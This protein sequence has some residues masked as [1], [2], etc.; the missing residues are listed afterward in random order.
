MS[1]AI[2]ANAYNLTVQDQRC[3]IDEV[4][5]E[6]DL[7]EN[8]GFLVRGETPDGVD[9]TLWTSPYIVKR[10]PESYYSGEMDILQTMLVAGKFSAEQK[11]VMN[12]TDFVAYGWA[13]FDHEERGFITADRNDERVLWKV[14]NREYEDAPPHWAIRGEHGGIDLDLSFDA[15]VPAFDVYPHDRFSEDGIAW[16]EAYLR[17]AGTIG[18]QGKQLDVSGYAC[19]ER[20]I[21]TRDHVPEKLRDRGLYWQHLFGDRVQAWVMTSPSA[22]EG[23]AYVVVD[24]ETFRAEGPAEVEIEDLDYWVDPRSWFRVPYRF[25]IKV[26]TTGGELELVAGAYARAYYPWTPFRDTVNILYWMSA[27]ATGTFTRNDGETVPIENE[28]YMAHSNRVIWSR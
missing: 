5:I 7:W 15:Y 17:A 28:K 1:Q 23:L 3:H 26:Q 14:G 24:G 2:D 20:V 25:K 8:H 6:Q 16:Y 27:E 12:D 4:T 18:Y 22:N 9:Y 13:P 19:H 21:V 11:K 10:G